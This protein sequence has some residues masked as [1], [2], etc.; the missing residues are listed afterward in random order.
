MPLT[1]EEVW[2]L[3]KET[4]NCTLKLDREEHEKERHITVDIM[5]YDIWVEYVSYRGIEFFRISPTACSISDF[6]DNIKRW[7]DGEDVSTF[8][9]NEDELFASFEDDYMEIAG[10]YLFSCDWIRITRGEALKIRD[11]LISK[12]DECWLGR[13]MKRR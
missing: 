8:N 12:S 5:N 7:Y 3:F 4:F 1:G 9:I 2:S 11:F 6:L 13:C 10:K